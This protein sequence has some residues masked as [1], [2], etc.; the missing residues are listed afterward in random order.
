MSSES[1]QDSCGATSVDPHRRSPLRCAVAVIAVALLLTGCSKRQEG[2]GEDID[3]CVGYIAYESM[4]QPSPDDPSEVIDFANVFLRILD[5]VEL[6]E[7]VTGPDDETV[8]VPQDVAEAYDTLE[9]SLK[10]LRE[11]VRTVEG[12]PQKV[13]AV[14]NAFSDNEAFNKADVTIAD[15]HRTKCD[16]GRYPMR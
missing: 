16:R 3:A 15:F 13:R 5:R 8:V 12:D 6:D 7:P 4:A 2:G 9:E 11:E 10:E 14:V 1:A